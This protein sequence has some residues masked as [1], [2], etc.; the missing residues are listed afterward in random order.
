[1]GPGVAVQI[2]GKIAAN[3]VVP[4]IAVPL[5]GAAAGI[6]SAGGLSAAGAPLCSS[7]AMMNT[8]YTIAN[9]CFARNN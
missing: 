9:D 1:L 8:C 6:T 3:V 4:T 7:L 2:K 5:T